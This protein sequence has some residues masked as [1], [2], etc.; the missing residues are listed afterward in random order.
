MAA[1]C[2]LAPVHSAGVGVQAASRGTMQ[3]IHDSGA[4]T[5]GPEYILPALPA[6]IANKTTNQRT[7]AQTIYLQT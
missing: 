4:H 6:L 7:N 3:T 5:S 2:A 1:P